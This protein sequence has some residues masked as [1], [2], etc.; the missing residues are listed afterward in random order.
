MDNERI[1]EKLKSLSPITPSWQLRQKCIS[2]R[3]I[4]PYRSWW[5]IAALLLLCLALWSHYEHTRWQSSTVSN[6]PDAKKFMRK[7][8]ESILRDDRSDPGVFFAREV[9]YQERNYFQW[10]KEMIQGQ[11]ILAIDK[12]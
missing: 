4:P 6:F 2:P 1:E 12:M 3:N 10:R 11:N 8:C 7:D 5:S 9:G